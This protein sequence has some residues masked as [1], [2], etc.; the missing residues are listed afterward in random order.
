MFAIYTADLEDNLKETL[1]AGDK[2]RGS[3]IC[4]LA[5]AN[6]VVILARREEELRENC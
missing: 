6:D 1:A 2:I 3:R 5:Y 4:S